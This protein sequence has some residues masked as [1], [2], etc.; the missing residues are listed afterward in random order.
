MT[1]LISNGEHQSILSA[2]K[3]IDKIASKG[4]FERQEPK[5]I[6]TFVHKL[7]SDGK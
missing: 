5:I 1:L 4:S 2:V 7:P 6:M 3:K